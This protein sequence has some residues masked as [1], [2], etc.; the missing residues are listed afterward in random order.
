[1]GVV[2]V[3]ARLSTEDLLAA[4]E[5][6]GPEEADEAARRLLQ[7]QARR[8]APSLPAREAALLSL[9]NQ[10]RRPG[11]G[12]RFGALED[13]RRAGRLTPEEHAELLHLVDESESRA[14]RRLEALAELAQLRQMSPDAL[15]EQLGLKAPLIG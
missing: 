15:M 10:A 6:L 7:L 4:L 13:K 14:A 11:F 8:K 5:Q 1:M 12:E 3:Q 9:V 2:S